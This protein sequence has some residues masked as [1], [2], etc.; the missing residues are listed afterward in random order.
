MRHP[1]R[2]FRSDSPLTGTT[3]RFAIGTDPHV[4]TARPRIV[5]VDD[6]ER[7]LHALGRA[8]SR[9][10]EVTLATDAGRALDALRGG[11]IAVLVTD[12]DL[13]GLSGVWLLE[14]VR[15][16]SPETRRVLMSGNQTASRFGDDGLVER[17]LSKPLDVSKLERCLTE[18]LSSSVG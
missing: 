5:L 8:L 3:V 12:N 1:V 10:F 16:L 18:L 13:P 4:S 2:G 7:L 14:Q 9:S 6:A 17:F 11:H 15:L